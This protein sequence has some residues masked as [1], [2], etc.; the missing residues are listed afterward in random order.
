MYILYRFFAKNQ[1]I[2][3]KKFQNAQK[4]PFWGVFYLGGTYPPPHRLKRH[5]EPKNRLKTHFKNRPTAKKSDGRNFFKK[6]IKNPFFQKQ[7]KFSK[8]FKISQFLKTKKSRFSKMRLFCVLSHF[9]RLGGMFY[10]FWFK[11]AS[12]GVSVRFRACFIL[13]L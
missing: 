6:Q 12:R 3:L 11:N 4:H 9:K 2:F 7:E 5:H 10:L 1:K 13:Y 8:N